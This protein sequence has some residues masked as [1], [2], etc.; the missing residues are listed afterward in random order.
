MQPEPCA[1][2]LLPEDGGSGASD[3]GTE[4]EGRGGGEEGAARGGGGDDDNDGVGG[5]GDPVAWPGARLGGCCGALGPAGSQ[6]PSAGRAHGTLRDTALRRRPRTRRPAGQHG[7]SALGPV[8]PDSQLLRMECMSASHTRQLL[9]A[10]AAARDMT[11]LLL[12][13]MLVLR[14]RPKG[15]WAR[16]AAAALG[17]GLPARA[18]GSAARQLRKLTH[19]LSPHAF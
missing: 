2:P 18:A 16:R 19:H 11:G 5:D 14:L 7:V 8:G 1:D 13:A 4:R 3:A 12:V 15:V 9:G 17:A 10:L 6:A